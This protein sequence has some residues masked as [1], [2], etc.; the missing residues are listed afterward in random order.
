MAS[1]GEA[2]RSLAER[3][4]KSA[5]EA[6]AKACQE[7]RRIMSENPEL[8]ATVVDLLPEL[9]DSWASYELD[10][11]ESA[12][13]GVPVGKL[14]EEIPSSILSIVSSAFGARLGFPLT[15]LLLVPPSP[16]VAAVAKCGRE[17]EDPVVEPASPLEVRLRASIIEAQSIAY[18][19]YYRLQEM[20][21]EEEVEEEEE[22]LWK[23]QS[24]RLLY[25]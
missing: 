18:R 22:G 13:E 23:P 11:V 20:L 5:E 24:A 16:L 12:G 3:F 25:M 4:G 8:V 17:T 6:A 21:E 19:V 9:I 7:I 14:I 15:V 1:E 10:L 2:G